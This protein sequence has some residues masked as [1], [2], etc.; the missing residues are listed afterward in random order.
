M[1]NS[2]TAVSVRIRCRAA[3]APTSFF[4][5]TVADS[6]VEASDIIE[7]F[8][9]LVDIINLNAIDASSSADG[10]QA[11]T[12]IGARAF[13]G[14]AGQLRVAAADGNTIV[15]GDVN[16]DGAADFAIRLTGNLLLTSADFVL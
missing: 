4:F 10:N 16:G 13:D 5:K 1:R 14:H 9:H 8:L 6:T 12:F 7:D 15:S 3:R 2:S 11:F